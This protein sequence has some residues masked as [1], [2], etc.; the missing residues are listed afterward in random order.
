VELSVGTTIA[1][2]CMSFGY[3]VRA[4][5]T[6]YWGGINDYTCGGKTQRM[7]VYVQ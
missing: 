2:Q 5:S 7:Q 1:C 3:Q 6:S 4:C